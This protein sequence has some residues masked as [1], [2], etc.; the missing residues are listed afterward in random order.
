MEY[1][2]LPDE[3]DESSY[4]SHKK[5]KFNR[6]RAKQNL[7]RILKANEKKV[8]LFEDGDISLNDFSFSYANNLPILKDINL[9]FKDFIQIDL[10]YF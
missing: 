3:V 9:N 10:E 2:Q 5:E 4:E 1:S 6:K 7:E 8:S